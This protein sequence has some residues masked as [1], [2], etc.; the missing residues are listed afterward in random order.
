MPSSIKARVFVFMKKLRIA[1][2][3]SIWYT[4]PPKLYGGTERVIYNLTEELVKRG[5][6]VTLFAT[7]DSKTISKLHSILKKPAYRQGIPWTNFLYPLYHIS[8]VFERAH[9]FDII[10]MHINTRQD[11]G[12]LVYAGM[13]KTPTLFTIHF[14]L[15]LQKRMLIEK[16]GLMFLK[17]YKDLNYNSISKAQQTLDFLNY[18]AVVHNGLDF[19]KFPLYEKPGNDLV[20]IGRITKDKGTREAIEVAKKSHTKLILAGKIDK[21]YEDDHYYYK[22]YI[23]K[24]IDGKQIKYIGEVNDAQKIKLLKKAKAVLMPIMWNEP[25]GLVPIEAM[26]AG[27][28]VIAFDKGP[29]RE[30]II[31]GKT[32]FIVKNIKEMAEAIKK[33][34]SLDRKKFASML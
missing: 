29:M 19:S 16:I 30:L 17:K 27:V 12:S 23:E 31:D 18:V 11:Y 9:E 33:V 34:D 4:T 20:W 15:P 8:E 28:P 1:Q 26:A 24:H 2:V 21:L 10:H 25:F 3:G 22:K 14:V 5:H 32:G 7:G 6:D 13:V